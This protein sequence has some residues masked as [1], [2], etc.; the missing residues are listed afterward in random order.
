M[1]RPFGLPAKTK[2]LRALAGAG[3]LA[4]SAVTLHTLVNLRHL[5]TVAPEEIS[6]DERVSVLIP[7]RNEAHRVTATLQALLA[8]VGVDDLEILI[9]DDG[10]IDDTQVVVKTAVGDDPR[11]T[12]I[13]GGNAPLPD[14]WLGKPW[15]CHRLSQHATGRVL[16]FLDADVV[17]HPTAIAATVA[18]MRAAGLDL[19]SPYPRQLAQTWPERITQPLVVWSW[20]ATLPLR[21]TE[22]THYPSLAAANGQFICVDARAYRISGGHTA[23]A[24]HVVEDVEVLRA[25]K[26]CGF[27]GAPANGG[28]IAQCRMY[29][30]A[31]E[32][33]EGYTKSL[34]TVFGSGPG[35]AA[36]LAVMV[37]GYISPPLFALA[38]RDRTQRAWGAL[39]YVA[40]VGGRYAV[41]RT[42][43]ERRWPDVALQ[44]ISVTTFAALTIESFRRKGNGTLRWRGRAIT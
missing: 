36:V 11:V 32:I 40:G 23:V 34:W 10:S 1:R 20:M 29:D 2:A 37:L 43:G 19:L 22:T 14:G 30:G 25:L 39:G 12:L 6:V 16:V 17:L 7:L 41:A 33:I 44:P 26:R 13:D 28:N 38:G 24:G 31:E 9:L 35:A 15:A 27:T 21:L 18:H 5:R 3:A 4:S 42:T 8:Q